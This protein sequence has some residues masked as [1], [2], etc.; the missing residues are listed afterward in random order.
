M[1]CNVRHGWQWHSE[2]RNARRNESETLVF[3]EFF[4]PAAGT[5]HPALAPG[6][7]RGVVSHSTTSSLSRPAGISSASGGVS[8]LAAGRAGQRRDFSPR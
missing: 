2:Q 1:V 7:L 5:L 8:P 4:E 6:W 3:P